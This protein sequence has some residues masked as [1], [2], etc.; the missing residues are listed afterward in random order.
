MARIFQL[1]EFLNHAPS[2]AWPIRWTVPIH[3]PLPSTGHVKGDPMVSQFSN[4][5]ISAYNQPNHFIFLQERGA[6]C[7]YRYREP[8]AHNMPTSIVQ[9][10]LHNHRT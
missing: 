9:Y 1:V 5:N 6:C 10:I 7:L 3:W 8:Q 4:L 2:H